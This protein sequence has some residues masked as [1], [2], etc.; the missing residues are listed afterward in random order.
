MSP[1]VDDTHVEER[2]R[3]A[4][5]D[6]A[7][8]VTFAGDLELDASPE[9]HRSPVRTLAVAGIAAACVVALAAGVGVAV[10]DGSS[11]SPG[12]RVATTST[13]A[14]SSTTPP[15]T[16]DPIAAAALGTWAKF[17]VGTVPRPLLLLEG[18]VNAPASGFTDPDIRVADADK[19]AF[20]AGAITSPGSFP[21]GPPNAGGYRIISAQTALERIRQSGSG[22]ASTVLTTT[23]IELG[24]GSFLTDRGPMTLPAWL[25]SFRGVTDPAEVLAVD[26]AALF[27]APDPAASASI[28]AGSAPG[29]RTLTLTFTGAAAG[30]GPCTADYA[31]HVSESTVA[32]AVG[33]EETT[34]DSTGVACLAVGYSRRVTITLTQPL[35]ARVLVD[36]KTQAAIEVTP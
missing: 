26:P 30:T 25:V 21:S 34:H 35:G 36:E 6:I 12:A 11:R 16:E 8:R 27:A 24:T 5:N 32:V 15:T 33:I 17:P 28:T 13:S 29:A 9:E 4:L 7:A 18:A 2:I 14:P 19:D 20:D 31:A 3:A 22:T 1:D 10:H 23:N